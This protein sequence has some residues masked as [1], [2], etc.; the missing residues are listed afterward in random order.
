[1]GRTYEV[2]EYRGKKLSRKQLCVRTKLNVIICEHF[3]VIIKGKVHWV[4]AKE[5]EACDPLFCNEAYDSSSSDEEDECENKG[6]LNGNNNESDK[7]VDRVSEY[8]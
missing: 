8:S 5:I 7:E 1:M 2:G 3:K 6:S 4:Y